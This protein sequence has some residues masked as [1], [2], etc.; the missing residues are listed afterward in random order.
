MGKT[1][2]IGLVDGNFDVTSVASN[3]PER[4]SFLKSQFG[5]GYDESATVFDNA[6]TNFPSPVSGMKI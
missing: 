1:Y 2:S 6:M 5:K 4:T 3:A